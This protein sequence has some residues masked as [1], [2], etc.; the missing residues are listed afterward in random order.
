MKGLVGLQRL[1]ERRGSLARGARPGA[2]G[3]GA[4][5]VLLVALGDAGGECGG[6]AWRQQAQ[7]AIVQRSDGSSLI[8]LLLFF[9]RGGGSSGSVG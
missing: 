6:V 9:L 2:D 1:D 7:Y 8:L 3:G 5:Q 4:G